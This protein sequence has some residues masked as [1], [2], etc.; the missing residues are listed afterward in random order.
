V[1]LDRNRVR[2]TGGVP[3]AGPADRIYLVLH[4]PRGYVTSRSDERGR[5]TV[6]DLL[7]GTAEGRW[8]FPVGRLDRDSEGLLLLTDDG[9]WAH[10][11]TDPAGGTEKRYR[12][13]LDRPL[14]PDGTARWREGFLL[15][16]RPTLPAPIAEEGEGWCRVSLVE[17]RNRQL[18]RMFRLLG[19][20]VRRLVRTGVGSLELGDLPPGE[21]RRL[22]PAEAASLAPLTPRRL[23]LDTRRPPV[24]NAP[25][26]EGRQR[27]RGGNR[28]G[29]GSPGQRRKER[30][31]A[32][33]TG[34][35]G[36]GEVYREKLGAAGVKS[37]K[38]LLEKGATPAGRKAMAK[39][40]GIADTLILKW[41]NRADLARVKGIGEEYADLLEA[42]GVDTVPELARRRSDNLHQ[43]MSEVN[44]EKKLVR[45]L[46]SVDQVA[47]WI[48]QA[49]SL[50]RIVTY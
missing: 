47:D 3:A 40:S 12:V 33:L 13:L 1:D 15:D 24:L 17:G 29:A 50:P 4:K 25:G 37:Q 42:A 10:R 32:K 20:R 16:G 2:L 30:G 48:V 43:K 6:Y 34:I 41:I 8:L 46:P 27:P 28:P 44:A 49:G 31:M 39:A 19:R 7:A 26:E 18:R 35:E 9:P 11:L 38:D 36:V 45:K 21:S 5:R 23:F 14:G 22:T